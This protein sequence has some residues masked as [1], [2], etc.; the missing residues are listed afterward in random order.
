MSQDPWLLTPGPLTTSMSVKQ[1][2]LH[3]WGSRDANFIAINARMRQRLVA[4]IGGEDAFACVPMQGSGTFAVEA[5]IG[6]FV[7]PAGKL[8]VLINGA[9]GKRIAR[10][11]DYY[12]RATAILEWPEDQLVD[13][14]W[15][16]KALA[17]DTAITHVAV[18]HCETTSGVLNPIAEVARV[19]AAAGRRLLID[20]MSAFGAIALDAKDVSFDA[21]AA[22]SN[23]CIEG[24]PGLGFI[25]ARVDALKQCQG[26]APSLSLDLYDQWQALEKTGQYRFTP[27]IHC[28]VAFD[29]ALTEHEQ[30]GGVAGRGARYRN[31]C[32]VLVDGMRAMGF[33]P[34]LPDHVQA[35]IIVTFHMPADPRFDFQA[36]Y[37][38]LKDRGYVIYPGKLTVADSFRI[39]CIGR[40]DESHMRG[41]LAAI[42]AVM[43]EMG[44]ASGSP[45]RQA[46]NAE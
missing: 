7:P 35:P 43:A 32:K 9:Y 1:A 42:R 37:D 14:A 11:C 17:A 4:M 3:D 27:P 15:V 23:K 28:I 19:V 36:F 30:E 21:V 29:Q 44:V 34:L 20:A 13:P 45:L 22:S 41:A 24:V 8:L 46:A 10:I 38:K 31:N 5:M 33:Q 26:N 2:M 6:A 40:L 16:A 12:K 18:V 39:G 25:L